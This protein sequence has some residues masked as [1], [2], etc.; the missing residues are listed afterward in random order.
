MICAV[1][2]ASETLFGVCGESSVSSPSSSSSSS[3]LGVGSEFV[4]VSAS[5]EVWLRVRILLPDGG[6]ELEWD[7]S[8][9]HKSFVSIFPDLGELLFWLSGERK[10]FL[11]WGAD[12][13]GRPHSLRV[14]LE[15]L[16]VTGVGFLAGEPV[17]VRFWGVGVADWVEMGKE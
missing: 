11:V 17:F 4:W 8:R 2:C 13:G 15:T 3:L 7:P 6:H 10:D 14:S 1:P 9:L 12:E 5:E 16:G